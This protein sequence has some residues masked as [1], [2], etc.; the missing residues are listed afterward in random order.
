VLHVEIAY[1]FVHKRVKNPPVVLCHRPLRPFYSLHKFSFADGLAFMDVRNKTHKGPLVHLMV[2]YLYKRG[3]TPHA[4][5]SGLPKFLGR[6]FQVFYYLGFQIRHLIFSQKYLNPIFRV[7][8]NSGSGLGFSQ[9][10]RIEHCGM[11]GNTGWR[12][13]REAGSRRCAASCC[14]GKQWHGGAHH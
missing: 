3:P 13:M 5:R 9:L 1:D 7:P 12:K 2:P 8:R 11:H 14:R 4:R 6:G 10:A